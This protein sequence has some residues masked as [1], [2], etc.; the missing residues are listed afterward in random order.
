LLF[1]GL[2][3]EGFAQL[4]KTSCN[5]HNKRR[6]LTLRIVNLYTSEHIQMQLSW[7]CPFVTSTSLVV[8]ALGTASNKKM[9]EPFFQTIVLPRVALCEFLLFFSRS[10]RDSRKTIEQSS[11]VFK[12]SPFA[13]KL[14]EII[15]A[16]RLE[17]N[18]P[19]CRNITFVHLSGGR[20]VGAAGAR[21]P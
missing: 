2:C 15:I 11:C 20:H 9:I 19:R 7:S 5:A 16:A 21:R 3:L 13:G 6:R 18:F 1:R 14:D 4:A 10:F 12:M 17:R 8:S